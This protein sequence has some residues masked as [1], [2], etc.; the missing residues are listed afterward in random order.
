MSLEFQR[1]KAKE[2]TKFFKVQAANKLINDAGCVVRPHKLL[3]GAPAFPVRML[4]LPCPNTQRPR[5]DQVQRDQQRA[6]GHV[7]LVGGH[8]DRVGNR[9][10]ASP[11]HT[12]AHA[13]VITRQRVPPC[14]ALQDFPNQLKLT[15]SVLGIADVYD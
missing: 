13:A 3:G 4:T 9:S 1:E 6:V 15:V 2:L 10:G 5:V 12:S 7:R 11:S 14:A 8:D